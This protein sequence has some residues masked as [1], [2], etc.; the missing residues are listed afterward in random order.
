[1]NFLSASGKDAKFLSV[2]WKTSEIVPGV[3]FA[4]YEP[5]LSKRIELTRR[6][7]ELTQKNEFLAATGKELEHLELAL[8][9]L[10]VQKQLVEWGLVEITGLQIDGKPAT[11]TSLI[12]SGPDKLVT[13][14]ASTIRSR[15]G[16]DEEERKNS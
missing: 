10:L 3:R 11:A 2:I 12:E 1:M 14:I 16:L 4:I 13:E 7:Y 15:C 9:D 5:T 8:A 6:L